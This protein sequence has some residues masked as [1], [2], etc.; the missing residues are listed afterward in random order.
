MRIRSGGIIP[1]FEIPKEENVD[2]TEYIVPGKNILVIADLHIPYHD[3]DAIQCAL[4]YGYKKKCDTVL[5]DGDFIDFYRVSQYCKDPR[6]RNVAE[7][8]EAADKLLNSICEHF[9]KVVWKEGNHEERYSNYVMQHAPEIWH[10]NGVHLPVLMRLS[11]RGI[12]WVGERRVMRIGDHLRVIHGNEY[13]QSTNNPVNPARGLFLR[14]K[15]CAMAAHNHQSSEHTETTIARK[16]ITDWSI[17]C[18]CGLHPQYMPLNKWNQGFS[19]VRVDGD[20]FHVEN[21]RIIDGRVI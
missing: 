11:E 6:A 2:Y 4:E 21:R 17:G 18:L 7:E 13:A 15:D 9:K 5:I 16:L 20:D 1:R 14:A 8:I 12:D 3:S 19:C 10:V